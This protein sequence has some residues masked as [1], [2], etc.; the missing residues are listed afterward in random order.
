MARDDLNMEN[1]QER[2]QANS[3]QHKG[4]SINI[5]ITQVNNSCF[6][7]N[8]KT[9]YNK[10]INNHTR[11]NNHNSKDN[12]KEQDNTR[13]RKYSSHNDSYYTNKF[14]NR[15]NKKTR[16]GYKWPF[17]ICKKSTH[18]TLLGCPELLRCIPGN[19]GGS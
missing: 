3:R 16:T 10:G 5:N 12:Y 6:H 14:R 11:S 19:P 17:R 13:K 1:F 4:I 2:V 9:N 8:Q 15:V 7:H 18:D